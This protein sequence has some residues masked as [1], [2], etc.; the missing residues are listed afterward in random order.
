[1]IGVNDPG[2]RFALSLASKGCISYQSLNV[3]LYMLKRGGH[4]IKDLMKKAICLRDMI[5]MN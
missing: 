2:Y 5:N 1:M 3:T 4:I